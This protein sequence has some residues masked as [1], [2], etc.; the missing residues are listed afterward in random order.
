MAV[1]RCHTDPDKRRGGRRRADPSPARK[2]M[3][4]E[5]VRR[6]KIWLYVLLLFLTLLTT[7]VAAAYQNGVRLSAMIADP[8]ELAVGFFFSLKLMMMILLVYALLK[9]P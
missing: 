6:N 9:S 5:V 4:G 1:D 7:S 8:S 2:L 3:N